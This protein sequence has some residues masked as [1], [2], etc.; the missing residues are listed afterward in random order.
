MGNNFLAD[1]PGEHTFRAQTPVVALGT[2]YQKALMIVPFNCT[3]VDIKVVPQAAVTGDNTD[4]FTLSVFNGGSGGT[5]TTVVASKA[6]TTGVDSV[7]KVP[8]SLTNSGTAANLALSQDDVLIWDKTEAASGLATVVM[9]V[10]FTVIA[11]GV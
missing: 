9:L 7:A 6:Y 1:I 11:R 4:N 5:G 8:E 2:D 3:I 10:E